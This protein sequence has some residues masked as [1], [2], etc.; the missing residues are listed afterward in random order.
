[1]NACFSV[2]DTLY[3]PRG[4]VFKKGMIGFNLEIYES[5]ADGSQSFFTDESL[6]AQVAS[7]L[8]RY[9]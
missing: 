4:G 8:Q 2:G 7:F 6:D 3:L 9:T 5:T 1:M